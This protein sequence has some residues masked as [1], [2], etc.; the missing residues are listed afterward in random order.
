MKKKITIDQAKETIKTAASMDFYVKAFF[1]FSLPGETPEDIMK[2]LKLMD[3]LSS[4]SPRV[5]CMGGYTLVYPGTELELLAKEQGLLPEDFQWNQPH[6]FERSKL[7]KAN[8]SIPVYENPDL[9]LEQIIKTANEERYRL[10]RLIPMGF[11]RLRQIRDF[12][13]LRIFLNEIKNTLGERIRQ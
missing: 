5:W 3:E 1:M 13:A 7:V 10:S 8:P 6:L 2:T 11:H 9:P 12:S 4:Y